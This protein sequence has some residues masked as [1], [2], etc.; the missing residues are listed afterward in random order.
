M[1]LQER[2]SANVRVITAARHMSAADLAAAMGLGRTAVVSKLVGRVRWN[3]D[4]LEAVAAALD[5]DPGQL[6][7]EEWEL[8]AVR[9]KGLEPPTFW[10]VVP[11]AT[12][13]ARAA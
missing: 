3:L 6:V 5:L 1:S 11:D 7:S 9:P 2:M 8:R 13:W 10:T 4:D 12:D